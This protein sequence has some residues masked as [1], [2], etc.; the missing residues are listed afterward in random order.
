MI[1]LYA[2]DLKTL[3]ADPDCWVLH[4]GGAWHGFGE[5]EEGYCMLDPVKVSVVTPRISSEGFEDQGIPACV[6]SRYLVEHN[7]VVEKATDF[8]ILFLFSI[9]ITKGKWS[10]LLEQLLKFK[11]D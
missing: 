5:I 11:Q 7:I 8:T 9:G 3:S 1:P 6:V 2:A 4:P 10:K